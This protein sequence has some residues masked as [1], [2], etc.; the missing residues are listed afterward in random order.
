MVVNQDTAGKKTERDGKIETIKRMLKRER[1]WYG[2]TCA[3]LFFSCEFLDKINKNVFISTG[4][5]F[6]K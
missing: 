5:N 4:F 6:K 1:A 3:E 2:K